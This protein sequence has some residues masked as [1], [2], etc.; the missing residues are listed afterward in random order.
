MSFAGGGLPLRG[1][2]VQFECMA[3]GPGKLIRHPIA[4]C[5]TPPSLMSA[6]DYVAPHFCC[7]ALKMHRKTPLGFRFRIWDRNSNPYD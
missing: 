2:P 3:N 6:A 5:N 1:D 4:T 7:I